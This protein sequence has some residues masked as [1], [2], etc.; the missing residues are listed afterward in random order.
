MAHHQKALRWAVGSWSLFIAENLILSENRTEIIRR[1]GDEQYHAIYGL[2]STVACGTILYSG[3]KIKNG[4]KD[5]VPRIAKSSPLGQ[6]MSFS[7]LGL[8]FIFV[9][10]SAPRLQVPFYLDP[11]SPR[12]HQTDTVNTLSSSPSSSSSQWKVRCPFDF[13]APEKE[14]YGIDRITRHSGL[15]SFG[16]IGTGLGMLCTSLP[17]KVWFSMPLMVALI[18]GEHTDSRYRRNMGGSFTPTQE[19]SSN[20]PFW[21]IVSGKQGDAF[22][23]FRSLITEEMKGINAMIALGMAGIIVA[24]KGRGA[25]SLVNSA[26]AVPNLI[27]K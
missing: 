17:A 24:R 7:M 18:G 14:I 15:W 3:Y 21:G 19:L 10:Q 27:K 8:G 22:K 11:P 13:H 9:S 20:V 5:I 6:A 25:S 1:F 12:Q 23:V 4:V 16:F 2:C 26:N